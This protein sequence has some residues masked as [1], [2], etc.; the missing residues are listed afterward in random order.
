MIEPVDCDIAG[1]GDEFEDGNYEDLL[2]DP[3]FDKDEL[4]AAKEPKQSD[5]D[6]DGDA[7]EDQPIHLMAKDEFAN[8]TFRGPML[9]EDEKQDQQ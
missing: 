9:N 4:L 3:L 1:Y 2:D 7:D 8:E 6:V 5:A